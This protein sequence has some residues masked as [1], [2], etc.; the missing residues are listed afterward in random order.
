MSVRILIG[1]VLE[2]IAEIADGSVH[3]VVT[4]PPYWGL[5]DYGTDGQ[6]GLEATP[7]EHVKRMVEVFREV[8]RVLRADGTLWLN[9]GDSYAQ[10]AANRP[11]LAGLKSKNLV[12]MPWRIAFALQADGWYL[13][14]DIIWAKPNPMPESVTDRPAKSHEYVFLLAKSAK[15][16][17]DADAVREEGEGYGRGENFRGDKYESNAAFQNSRDWGGRSKGGGKHT[18]KGGRNLRDVWTIATHAYPGAHFATFPP[19]L[20]MPCI[21]AG[22]SEEGCCSVCG[23][24]LMRIVEQGQLQ[25]DRHIARLSEIEK[26]QREKR[27]KGWSGEKGFQKNAFRSKTTIDWKPG[28]KHTKASTV[29]STVLDPFGGAGT[30]GLV[31]DQLQRNAILIEL[32]DEYARM[33]KRRIYD[34]CPMFTRVETEGK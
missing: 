20:V 31:A 27:D 23:A 13:R 26:D 7:E 6:L 1:D 3:C 8:K 14:S 10:G 29:P 32:N 24:P 21:K 34:D 22:T 15:Y 2:R 18:Y 5:R 28:C 4:S 30:V 25:P 12:G 19:K 11:R 33:A 17:Y 9:Y 16:Y